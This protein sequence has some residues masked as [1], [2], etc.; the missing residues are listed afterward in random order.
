MAYP[1]GYATYHNS[2]RGNKKKENLQ[3]NETL[4]K[5]I[6]ITYIIAVIAFLIP[7]K[8]YFTPPTDFDG[9]PMMAYNFLFFYPLV[10]L[11]I[12]LSIIVILRLKY[13]RNEVLSKVVLI[14]SILPSSIL[15]IMVFMNFA[16]IVNEPEILDLEIHTNT[17]NL[18]VND[19]LEIKLH[20]FTKRTM[21]DNEE[22]IEVKI[23]NLV[24]YVNG[25]YSFKD[26][27]ELISESESQDIFYKIKNDSLIVYSYDYEFSFFNKTRIPLPY[28]VEDGENLKI[29]KGKLKKM[30]FKKFE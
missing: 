2:V 24:P 27:G 30:E 15:L 8:L 13:F 16:Q 29:K 7:I 10:F 20:G 9:G 23:V 17:I 22:I 14:I 11:S 12:I 6:R 4:R 25:K 28:R 1:S 21:G 18:N 3:I 19:S 26:G 5:N